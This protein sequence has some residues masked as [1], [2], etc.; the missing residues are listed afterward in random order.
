LRPLAEALAEQNPNLTTDL[1]RLYR[2]SSPEADRTLEERL[3][4]LADAATTTRARDAAAP[5]GLLEATAALQDLALGHATANQQN[6]AEMLGRFY[7]AEKEVPR[8]IRLARNGPYLLS[9]VDRLLDGLGDPIPSHPQIALCRCGE[10]TSKPWC[11]GSHALHGFTDTKDPKRVPDRHDR[12][13]GL[14]VTVLDNRGICQHSGFCTDRLPVAFR[15]DQE[16]FVAPSGAR[17]DEIVRA[18][19]NCPS[20]ALSYAVDGNE[21]RDDVDWH[22]Q[23]PPT[24]TVTSDGP[25][26]VTGSI[27]LNEAGGTAVARNQGA[28]LEHY[29]LCR[30]GHSQNKPFCSGMHWY[31][32]FRDPLP[33]PDRE[34]TLYEWCGG[35][36]SLTRM[37]RLFFERHVPDD[38]LLGPVFADAPGDLPERLAQWLGQALGGPPRYDEQHGGY[39]NLIGAHRGRA[40]TEQQRARFVTLLL[41]SAEETGMPTDPEY[42]SAFTSYIEWQSRTIA[43]HSQ[44]SEPPPPDLPGPLWTW[45]PAG[46]PRPPTDTVQDATA[47]QTTPP[48]ADEPISFASH[49]Q[50]LFRSKDRQSMA[51]AFDL[52]SYDAVKEHAQAIVGRLRAG[53]MPCDGAWAEEKVALFQ[54]WI[55]E[56][57]PA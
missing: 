19:R 5:T 20:G 23:R 7:L 43:E 34:P 56:G 47:D 3:H 55:D 48:G 22:H 54:R 46:I 45:G 21:A 9:N 44:S 28:S 31:I 15:V 40:I 30:C 36:P 11:D 53:T 52:W 18:V 13:P 25:Y 57:M 10:S 14:A 16:P 29:A 33:A 2:A 49:I 51:F 32:G 37:T 35:M 4:A 38:P 12:Y 8:S 27:P 39:A 1:P 42:S 26:R 41:R 24:V 50:P 17:Q 6:R